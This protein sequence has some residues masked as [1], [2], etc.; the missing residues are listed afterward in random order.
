MKC[1]VGNLWNNS[2]QFYCFL[3]LKLWSV[4]KEMEKY[5]TWPD[6]KD[7]SYIYMF[8]GLC[9]HVEE[10][11]LLVSLPDG[12]PGMLAASAGKLP[13]CFIYQKENTV[14]LLQYFTYENVWGFS[15]VSYGYHY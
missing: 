10:K 11:W 15:A 9:I 4:I 6:K 3:K 8:M 1:C 5:R 7:S 13:T 14:M 2:S 12:W